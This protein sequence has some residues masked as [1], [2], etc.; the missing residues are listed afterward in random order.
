MTP[1]PFGRQRSSADSTEAD[2]VASQNG[3]G[4]AAPEEKSAAAS[5]RKTSSRGSRGGQGRRAAESSLEDKL[6]GTNEEPKNADEPPTPARRSRGGRGGRRPKAES[7]TA[8]DKPTEQTKDAEPEDKK[9]QPAPRRSRSSS[10]RTARKT[11]DTKVFAT[12][13]LAAMAKTIEEQGNQIAALT[14]LVESL[15]QQAPAPARATAGE[16]VGVFVDAANVE[17]A[18]EVR[19]TTIDWAKVLARLTDGRQLVR[20]VAYSPVS[21]DPSVSIETQ[22]FVEPFID[23]GY[24]VETKPLKRFHGGAIKANL[25]IE[26]ALDVI[27]MIDRLD[28]VCLLSG[29]GDFEALVEAVQSHG[30]RVEIVSFLHNTAGNLRN[31]ADQFMDLTKFK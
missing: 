14:K 1:N 13:D 7:D 31:A 18:R 23:G 30:V 9:A 22:R 10:S 2:A 12:A 20:A 8:L 4:S 3:S 11:P 21:D 16:R 5:R 27:Q 29:D 25:D 28:V 24:R 6:P 17:K 15:P 19:R 26:I